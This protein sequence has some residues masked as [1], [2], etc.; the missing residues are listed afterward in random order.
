MGTDQF[1]FGANI[2]EGR[3]VIETWTPCTACFFL[4]G[5]GEEGGGGS[6]AGSNN[7]LKGFSQMPQVLSVRM[8]VLK[9]PESR[10][11][12]RQELD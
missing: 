8:I 4:E 9:L 2:A 12:F 6:K 10:I 3:C 7:C 11:K 1:F 5:G